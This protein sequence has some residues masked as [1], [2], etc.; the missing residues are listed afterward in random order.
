MNYDIGELVE[1]EDFVQL[2][3]DM[4]R[5]VVAIIEDSKYSK[6]YPKEN[7]KYLERG[8]LVLSDQA[9]LV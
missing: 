9:G 2:S 4:F 6:L 7:W 5:V 3:S 8:I 1:L